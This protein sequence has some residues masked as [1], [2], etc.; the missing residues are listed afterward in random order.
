MREEMFKCEIIKS[1][2]KMDRKDK[3]GIDE[4]KCVKR[5]I[6]ERWR[7]KDGGEDKKKEELLTFTMGVLCVWW[8]ASCVWLK[9]L[10]HIL[11]DWDFFVCMCVYGWVFACVNNV[12]A[13]LNL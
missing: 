5:V 1:G 3:C 13:L 6:G 2:G 7:Q 8:K 9:R 11:M 12:C 4:K 10:L